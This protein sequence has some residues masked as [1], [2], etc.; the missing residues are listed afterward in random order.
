MV[1]ETRV[2]FQVESYQRVKKW[3]LMPPCLTHSII[4]YGLRLKW[5]NPKKGIAPFPTPRVSNY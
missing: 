4:R 3:C 2:Q 5:S 1:W